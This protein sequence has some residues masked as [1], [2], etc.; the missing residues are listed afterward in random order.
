MNWWSDITEY[1]FD[2]DWIS[3]NTSPTLSCLFLLLI[4]MMEQPEGLR[5]SSLSRA[6]RSGRYCRGSWSIN[7]RL[8][9]WLAPLSAPR[10]GRKVGMASAELD[11]K[12][13]N[14]KELEKQGRMYNLAASL[15]FNT[16]FHLCTCECL[17]PATRRISSPN[18]AVTGST[19]TVMSLPAG[20]S[21]RSRRTE[22]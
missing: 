3:A 12:T 14:C 10:W 6:S 17:K 4:R 20:G 21:R 1:K 18:S 11:V 19:S 5:S 13:W 9:P 2:L 16:S 7:M 22:L 8:K 15:K